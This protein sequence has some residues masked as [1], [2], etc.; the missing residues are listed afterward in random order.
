MVEATQE[1]IK[2]ND[3][4]HGTPGQNGLIL[5]KRPS[6][7]LNNLP[8][9]LIMLFLGTLMLFSLLQAKPPQSKADASA[10][11]S[12]LTL[13][14]TFPE[15]NAHAYLIKIAGQD[16]ILAR[17]REWKKLPPASLT[18]LLTAILAYEHL[19]DYKK[20]AFSQE[21]LATENNKTG[22]RGREEFYARDLITFLVISSAN[23]AAL[24][25]AETIGE[26]YGGVNF[27]EKIR[28]FGA[29]MN[30][31]AGEIGLR[32]SSFKNPTGLD[33]ADH[34]STA[35][36][37]ALLS[38]Y[39]WRNYPQLWTLTR[40]PQ[41]TIFSSAGQTYQI[42]NTNE[43]LEEFPAILG[44]KTGFTDNAKGNLILLYPIKKS[45]DVAIIVILRSEDRF[46]DGRKIIQ[47]LEFVNQ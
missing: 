38:E 21:S 23:D 3:W 39:T 20:V 40:S 29:L 43:L 22:A 1:I 4:G 45:G 28:A 41:S 15:L 27:E 30:K 16:L 34:L 7:Y 10:T 9:L 13:P 31:K 44:G 35:E 12:L 14:D 2:M 11:A 8:R 18:K 36:D 42:A 26:K 19:N 37:L 47:W 32:N 17:Q 5:K 33:E 6:S 46:G 24:L 25:L